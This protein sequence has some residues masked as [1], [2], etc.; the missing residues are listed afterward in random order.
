[1]LMPTRLFGFEWTRPRRRAAAVILIGVGHLALALLGF[2]SLLEFTVPTVY[3]FISVVASAAVWQ[4]VFLTLSIVIFLSVGWHSLE[5]QAM[6]AS[7][8]FL[9]TWAFFNFLWGISTVN[10]Q[11]VSLAGP[12]LGFILAGASYLLAVHP[13]DVPG[14][15]T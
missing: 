11:P 12:T 9:G 7:A 14:E 2:L 10:G 8:G 5:K 3:P 1:M 13:G 6:A 4:W 15:H